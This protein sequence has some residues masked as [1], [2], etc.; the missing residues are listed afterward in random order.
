M[1]PKQGNRD[2]RLIS[3]AIDSESIMIEDRKSCYA[4]V[5]FPPKSFM[6]GKAIASFA[7]VR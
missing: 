2:N 5:P 1:I 3:E 7:S 6:I 4:N